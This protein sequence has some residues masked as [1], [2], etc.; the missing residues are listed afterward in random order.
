MTVLRYVPQ[1]SVLPIC[2][3][4]VCHGGYST[5]LGAILAGLPLVVIPQ[6]SDH[7]ANARQCE[8][9]GV[10]VTVAPEQFS[11]EV[12]R[13]AANRVLSDPSFRTAARSF[14]ARAAAAAPVQFG[15]RLVAHLPTLHRQRIDVT[16]RPV[17]GA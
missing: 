4:V 7:Q 12:V 11:T 8:R 2:S 1:S 13:E 5:V 6:G 14:A 10:G 9:L 15:A 3:L 16:G 17:G